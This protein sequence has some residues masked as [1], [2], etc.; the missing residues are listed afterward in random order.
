M[1]LLDRPGVVGW[2]GALL[3]GLCRRCINPPGSRQQTRGQ[4]A[5]IQR[6][7][8][9]LVQHAAKGPQHRSTIDVGPSWHRGGMRKRACA[10]QRF[11]GVPII[12]VPGGPACPKDCRVTRDRCI[13]QRLCQPCRRR[14]GDRVVRLHG[15]KQGEPATRA[16]V[17]G[18]GQPLAH[19]VEPRH[20]RRRDA[21]GLQPGLQGRL[22]AGPVPQPGLPP[23]PVCDL[24]L[25][26]VVRQAG[27]QLGFV[28]EPD[29]VAACTHR[30]P[31]GGAHG[32]PQPG[33]QHIGLAVGAQGRPGRSH[34]AQ[35]HDGVGRQAQP[36]RRLLLQPTAHLLPHWL[37][38]ALVRRHLQA[39][40]ACGVAHRQFSRFSRCVIKPCAD[41]CASI[42]LPTCSPTLPATSHNTRP[43]GWVVGC[44]SMPVSAPEMKLSCTIN[45]LP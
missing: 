28:N 2:I 4:L 26:A 30:C 17:A 13:R 10:M 25:Q 23:P 34:A 43:V 6:Q 19:G 11:G 29:G 3:R 42:S 8:R 7:V 38:R 27:Q 18:P 35:Q 21:G 9:C 39:L 37:E 1:R 20:R 44:R 33:P 36:R 15:L 12:G 40:D 41:A 16:D 45:W 22:A 31:C 24:T 32:M 14:R 5:F